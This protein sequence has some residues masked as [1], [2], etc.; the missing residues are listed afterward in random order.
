MGCCAARRSC[1]TPFKTYYGTARPER[2][3]RVLLDHPEHGPAA[4]PKASR[5]AFR[6]D[7]AGNADHRSRLQDGE[8]GSMHPSTTGAVTRVVADM[9]TGWARPGG[10]PAAP[11]HPGP[12]GAGA[13]DHPR[14]GVKHRRGGGAHFGVQHGMP[15]VGIIDRNGGLLKPEGFQPGGNP[16]LF[17]TRDGNALA[18]SA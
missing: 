7:D 11:L 5:S 12:S 15:V 18:V 2:T 16:N 13:R 6:P 8:Q 1:A 10:R 17:L 3:K 4:L 9:I 14:S